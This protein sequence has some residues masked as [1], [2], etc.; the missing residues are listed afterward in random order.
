M[1]EVVLVDHLDNEIGTA[2]KLTAHRDGSL[3]RAFSIFLFNSKG[4]MLLQKRAAGK[5][6]SANLWSNSCCSHPRPAENLADAA[7]R[8]M[9][10]ELGITTDL[11]WLLSFQYKIDFDNG[12]IEHELDHVFVGQ[13]DQPM[14]LN[15]DEV[16]EIKYINP[17]Q[18]KKDIAVHPDQYTFWFKELVDR[19][20]DNY[21]PS[22]L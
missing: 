5:Y 19:V 9:R 2:E 8:R 10:E 3:H 22:I 14:L 16:S 20:L 12:L 7:H 1:E 21:Q 17:E 6:H 11:K 4:E 18:L 13:T 15:P